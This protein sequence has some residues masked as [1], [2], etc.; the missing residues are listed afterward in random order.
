MQHP[1]NCR[2]LKHWHVSIT[3]LPGTVSVVPSSLAPRWMRF[4]DADTAV[5]A[6]AA[7]T[8]VST[9]LKRINLGDSELGPT[10]LVPGSNLVD[11][12]HWFSWLDV[13]S[14]ATRL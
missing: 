14:C 3:L 12:C 1:D 6:C 11:T 9:S 13:L 10:L 8:A 2:P 5:A 4:S 7:T